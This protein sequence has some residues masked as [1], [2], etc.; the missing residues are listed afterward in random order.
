MQTR[1]YIGVNM[2]NNPVLCTR[3]EQLFCFSGVSFTNQS[4]LN[5]FIEKYI[6]ANSKQHKMQMSSYENCKCF[7]DILY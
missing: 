1:L 3:C 7:R 5:T 2:S 4:D 6:I